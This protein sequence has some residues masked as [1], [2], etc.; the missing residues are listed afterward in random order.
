MKQDGDYKYFGAISV[1]IMA[2]TLIEVLFFYYG[3]IEVAREPN[4]RKVAEVTL[5]FFLTT[6]IIGAVFIVFMQVVAKKS[7][8]PLP[9][10]NSKPMQKIESSIE[11]MKDGALCLSREGDIVLSNRAA[12]S[13][14]GYSKNE[15]QKQNAHDLMYRKTE[16]DVY[17]PESGGD[18]TAKS[19]GVN[20]ACS[21]GEDVYMKKDGSKIE[22]SYVTVPLI[23]NGKSEG[24]MLVFS[25]IS[26][27]KGDFRK[28]LVAGII[29]KTLKEGILVADSKQNIVF[30]NS[31][32]E[33]MTGYQSARIAGKKVSILRSGKHEDSFYKK[34]WEALGSEGYWEGEIWSKRRDGKPFNAW[35]SISV[36]QDKS[37][38]EGKF[39]IAVYNDI[40]K[41]KLHEKGNAKSSGDSAEEGR[42]DPLTG[43]PDM[44]KFIEA[45]DMELT[46]RG[47][48]G[49]YLSMITLEV[50]NFKT[51]NE[52]HGDVA[53][54]NTLKEL[55]N[56]IK[57]SIRKIDTAA[58]G[59]GEKFFIITP[60]TN[61][62][63]AASL[64]ENLRELIEMHI[65]DAVGRVSCSFG[66]ATIED[67]DDGDALIKR[68]GEAAL[69]SKEEGGNKIT[70]L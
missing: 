69:I 2:A 21:S 53:A 49:G 23:I 50:D 64:A 48:Y 36:V 60:H 13:L 11:F 61:I 63:G 35:L 15:L 41:R 5:S 51:I 70:L 40:S 6:A 31:Y 43:L 68:A 12:L 18:N 7:L 52:T 28:V 1:F 14:L 26:Q 32:F 58:S 20:G 3:A 42:Y 66:V 29:A 59:E 56:F 54:K 27:K 24:T 39:Y 65:F 30:A 10:D 47:R 17:L 38:F 25:D 67:G 55:A 4:I 45:L 16:D 9:F 44:E 33:S 46:R 37:E 34:M 62:K 57:T 8:S 22:V 19:L